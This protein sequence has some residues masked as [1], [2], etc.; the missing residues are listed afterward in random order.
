[1]GLLSVRM[2]GSL[3]L[4]PLSG[5]LPSFGLSC[6]ILIIF[7]K[8]HYILL[9]LLF[10]YLVEACPFLM[11]GERKWIWLEELGG[12]EGRETVQSKYSIWKKNKFSVKGCKGKIEIKNE[13]MNKINKNLKR[14][15]MKSLIPKSKDSFPVMCGNIAAYTSF[16]HKIWIYFLSKLIYTVYAVFYFLS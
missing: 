10:C 3:I 16:K 5:F 15:W 13:K 8:Y 11:K 2:S 9:F 14:G 4:V 7:L 1:M 12:V 6:T